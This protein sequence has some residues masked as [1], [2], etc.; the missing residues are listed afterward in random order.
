[1]STKKNK[2]YTEEEL[3][4]RKVRRRTIR[5]FL[6]FFLLF[7]LA[8]QAWKWIDNAPK[9]KKASKPL[10]T[11][12]D[13][14]A[15]IF[16]RGY[17]NPSLAKEFSKSTAARKVRVNGNI[18]L[19]ST[20][21]TTD[22]KVK[23][24]RYSPYTPKLSDTLYIPVSELM[25]LPKAEVVFSFKC[26][27]GWS[28]VSWWGGVR[29]LDVAKKYHLATIDGSEPDPENHPEKL[30]KFAGLKTPDGQYY[31]GIDMPS[32]L[33]PQT[34]LSFEVN[35]NPLPENQGA[36]IRLIIPVKYGIKHLKRI[37]TIFFSQTPPPDYWA[38]RG[39]DY[40]SGL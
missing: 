34:I 15:R 20:Y 39:Y 21:D 19:K 10:R 36:P 12:M 7:F 25:L 1:M 22:Y 38:D 29:F 37:G 11:V 6:I 16:A 3:F 4:D 26:I 27:E 40:F 14:N 24:V 18:G 31:V 8:F 17:K 2:T 35:G 30:C 5:S 33:H 9:D 32:M 28:Q 13:L 23:L